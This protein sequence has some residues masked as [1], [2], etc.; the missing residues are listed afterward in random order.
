LLLEAEKP[1]A[2]SPFG[3]SLTFGVRVGP[4]FTTCTTSKPKPL[5]TDWQTSSHWIL[6]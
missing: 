1:H 6:S 5:S 4:I 2:G 3:K